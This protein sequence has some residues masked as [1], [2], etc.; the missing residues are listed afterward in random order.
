MLLK[1]NGTTL[2]LFL[3]IPLVSLANE[4]EMLT[5]IEL[6]TKN[7][8]PLIVSEW[9]NDALNV[10]EKIV[11]NSHPKK[12]EQQR[13]PYQQ[14]PYQQEQQPKKQHSYYDSYQLSR[15]DIVKIQVLLNERGFNVGKPDGIP[16]AKT[17]IAIKQYQMQADLPINGKPS[18]ELLKHLYS[19][20]I[21]AVSV[22]S[23]KPNY[24]SS[25]KETITLKTH[26]NSSLKTDIV[27]FGISLGKKFKRSMVAN[28]IK[29]HRPT[30]GGGYLI[31][32]PHKPNPLFNFYEVSFSGSIFKG[33][34]DV[35]RI[36]VKSEWLKQTCEE[37]MPSLMK[38]LQNKYGH[39]RVRK[40]KSGTTLAIQ[41]D[42]LEKNSKYKKTLRIN[43]V[44]N[45][46]GHQTSEF[47]IKYSLLLGKR[48][49]H[50][51]YSNT[52]M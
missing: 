32:Q 16:G 26:Q 28:V 3:L 2:G 48:A 42:D 10:I 9:Y 6:P 24:Q 20:Q 17:T 4:H 35:S 13:T 43:A 29:S 12:N 27:V 34:D 38:T 39:G 31:V 47:R 46:R 25:K 51:P 11:N 5:V 36:T 22:S 45:V 1:K 15:D 49:K 41:K 18:N 50:V 44:C 52:G 33:K 40:G 14:H 37:T 19:H 30:G 7:S 23:E 8:T 21:R